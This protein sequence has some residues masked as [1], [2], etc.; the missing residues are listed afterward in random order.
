MQIRY[1]AIIYPNVQFG[2]HHFGPDI[3]INQD[4]KCIIKGMRG[5]IA[6][7]AIIRSKVIIGDGVSIGSCVKIEPDVLIGAETKIQHSAQIAKRS[8]IGYRCFIGSG[9][10][11]TDTRCPLCPNQNICLK[12]V[13]IENYVKIGANV[14]VLP[15]VKI[16]VNSLIGCGSVVTKDIPPNVVAFGN[17]CRVI[18]PITETKCPFIEG[19]Q[20]YQAIKIIEGCEYVE[21]EK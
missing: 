13:E 19:F 9:F 7:Y 21:A 1:G 14:S 4:D 2:S 10:N 20:P 11:S 18:K 15:G 6:H 17:P 12:G 8:H 16:G 5:F 3:F